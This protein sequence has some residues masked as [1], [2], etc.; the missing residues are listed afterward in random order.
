[1]G[2]PTWMS[3]K[4]MEASMCELPSVASISLARVM[5][6]L[7]LGARQADS[8]GNSWQSKSLDKHSSKSVRQCSSK[9]FQI[10]AECH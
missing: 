8:M 10:E 2:V 5:G 1:M 6:S 3:C 4:G 9:A 7:H